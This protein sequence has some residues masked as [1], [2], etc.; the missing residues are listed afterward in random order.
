MAII[1]ELTLYILSVGGGG[2]V[3]QDLTRLLVL[4]LIGKPGFHRGGKPGIPPPPMKLQTH[5]KKFFL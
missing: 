5:K 2:G 1:G 4:V 3:G